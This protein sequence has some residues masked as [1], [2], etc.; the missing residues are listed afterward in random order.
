MDKT[1]LQVLDHHKIECLYFIFIFSFWKD[2]YILLYSHVMFLE[3]DNIQIINNKRVIQL[4]CASYLSRLENLTNVWSDNKHD[5][6][7]F[8]LFV[9]LFGL[10]DHL[11]VRVF[12]NHLNCMIFEQFKSINYCNFRKPTSSWQNYNWYI[13]LFITATVRVCNYY[14]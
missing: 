5:T 6:L 10:W 12:I 1:F 2:V 11:W 4:L 9:S 13:K 3:H 8:S 14:I 7:N